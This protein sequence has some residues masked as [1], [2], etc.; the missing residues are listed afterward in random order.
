[1]EFHELAISGVYRLDARWIGDDRGGFARLFCQKEFSPYIEQQSIRQINYSV[2][3]EKGTIRG[4]HFQTPPHAEIKIVRCVKGAVFD[5]VVDL[6][7]ESKTFLQSLALTLSA[8]NRDA[9]LIPRGCAHGF[10]VLE[11]DS[12]L[13]YFHTEYYTP[14][15]EG[16]LRYDDPQLKIDWPLTAVNLSDRDQGHPLLTPDFC[17]ITFP[18]FLTL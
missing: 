13:L 14:N 16:G 12:E 4:L 17:G 11:E 6:R 9:I 7:R 10:Q 1:M 5:V 3:R 18:N 8:E 15:A 2:N